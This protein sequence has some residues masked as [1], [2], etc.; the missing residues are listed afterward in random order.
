MR[1]GLVG[2]ATA[3]VLLTG[4]GLR[5]ARQPARP[6]PGPTDGTASSLL[7]T[8]GAGSPPAGPLSPSA[9][10]AALAALLRP[11]EG[12]PVHRNGCAGGSSGDCGEGGS[13]S[14]SPAALLAQHAAAMP[15]LAGLLCPLSGGHPTAV[16]W[17]PGSCGEGAVFSAVAL[18]ADLFQRCAVKALRGDYGRLPEW[19]RRAYRWGLKHGVTVCGRAKRTT[20]CPRCSGP[21]CADGSH[22]RRGICAASRNIPMHWIVWLATDGLLLVTDRGGAV[23]ARPPY[24]RPGESA[25]F[26]VWV[27][28]CPGGCWHGS[29]TR[30]HVP[31][32]LLGHI[33]TVT[34]GLGP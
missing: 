17:L 34:G 7:R 16:C 30:H 19:K 6:L 32:A 10:R 31:Y 18:P 8:E 24:V 12:H 11:G 21:I 29:G 5:P 14:S 15:A 33:R 9:A 3:A 20:Y 13:G 1:A 4:V 23:K 22:V 28:R 2:A 27:P 26:D 25:N